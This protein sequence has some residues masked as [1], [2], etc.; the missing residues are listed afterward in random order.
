VPGNIPLT[1]R[2]PNQA[3][4]ILQAQ[5]AGAKKEVQ[6]LTDRLVPGLSNGSIQIIRE[7]IDAT[8]QR[9]VSVEQQ[10]DAAVSGKSLEATTVVNPAE[11]KSI[12]PDV[13]DVIFGGMFLAVAIFLGGPI[14]RAIARRL[15]GRGKTAPASPQDSERFERMEQAVDAIAIEVE[16]ISENQRYSTRLMSEMRALPAEAAQPVEVRQRESVRQETSR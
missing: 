3:I 15:E 6:D 16:R 13:K 2:D 9:L 10:L 12:P 7:Q 5:I 4:E 1:A 11:G 8:Q 14:A